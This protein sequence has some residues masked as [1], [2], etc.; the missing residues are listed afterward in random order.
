MNP[1]EGNVNGFGAEIPIGDFDTVRY[2]NCSLNVSLRPN[3]FNGLR[4]LFICMA[5]IPVAVRLNNPTVSEPPG[6]YP[7]VTDVGF[8][9]TFAYTPLINPF[10][11]V[12]TLI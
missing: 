6:R 8:F 5:L 10:D 9:G 12:P 3:G 1:L 11:F 4:V 7:L 2:L